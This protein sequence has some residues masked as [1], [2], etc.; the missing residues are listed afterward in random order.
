MNSQGIK[1]ISDFEHTLL[2]MAVRYAVGRRSIASS[3]LPMDII[4]NWGDRLT[5]EQKRLMF[6]DI[7]ETVVDQLRFNEGEFIEEI[8]ENS[9][10]KFASWLDQTNRYIVESENKGK[11]ETNECFLFMGRY[12]P[13][14]GLDWWMAPEFIKNV[15]RVD[16]E[17]KRWADDVSYFYEI[18]IQSGDRK[19][20]VERVPWLFG[21]Q[22]AN[23]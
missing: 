10:I 2:W 15:E 18:Q 14:K 13:V 9:W 7:I 17:G 3:L 11:S 12:Y 4:R 8:K 19:H 6:R 20:F 5:E 23:A 1:Q 22:E 21:D 16:K